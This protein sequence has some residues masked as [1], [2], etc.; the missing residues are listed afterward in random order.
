MPPFFL[1][2]TFCRRARSA[3]RRDA[4]KP[5]CGSARKAKPLRGVRV[6]PLR[7]EVVVEVSV[8]SIAAAI[9]QRSLQSEASSS[10]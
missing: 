7:G 4:N 9:D 1:A 8:R 2:A 10:A 5:R 3:R 6:E